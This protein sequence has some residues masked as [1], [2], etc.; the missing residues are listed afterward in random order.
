MRLTL[1]L[2]GER[3]APGGWHNGLC[4]V[5]R[6]RL[7]LSCDAWAQQHANRWASATFADVEDLKAAALT[8]LVIAARKWNP[9]RGIKFITYATRWE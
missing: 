1:T 5:E 3:P 4:D 2:Y 8:G 9:A 6:D 7:V